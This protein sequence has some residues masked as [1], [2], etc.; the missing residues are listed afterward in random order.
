MAPS[1]RRRGGGYRRG[2]EEEVDDGG[3]DWHR[4]RRVTGSNGGRQGASPG[5]GEHQRTAGSSGGRGLDLAEEGNEIDI[6]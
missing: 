1:G 6:D 4:D 2:D 5:S 3:D